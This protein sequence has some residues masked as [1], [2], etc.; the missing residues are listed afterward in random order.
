MSIEELI[1]AEDLPDKCPPAD[2]DVPDGLVFYRMVSSSTP[3]DRDF[4]SIRKLNPHQGYQNSECRAMSTSMF[5]ELSQCQAR[6][7]L[8]THRDKS[9][10]QIALNRGSGVVKQ[11]GSNRSH[12]SW[13][14]S[15][16]YDSFISVNDI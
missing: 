1:W 14:R 8:P 9:V 4:W 11:T 15:A 3:I 6:L 12:H 10:V 13:W 7:K 16:A 2:A 5:D